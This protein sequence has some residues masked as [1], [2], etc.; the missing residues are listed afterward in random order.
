MRSG[1]LILAVSSSMFL[2]GCLS[3]PMSSDEFRKIAKGGHMFVKTESLTV[4]RSLAAVGGTFKKKAPEC[5]EVQMTSQKKPVIGFAGA[6]RVYAISRSTVL[7]SARKVELIV[8]VKSVGNMAKEP[9]G[10]NYIFV[11]DVVPAGANKV[12]MDVYRA[13]RTDALLAAVKGWATGKMLGCPDP[14]TFM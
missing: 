5:L 10:G 6:P 3:N 8:Q 1:V 11:A 12:R 4:E 14:T 2:S 7:V 9:E 13:P